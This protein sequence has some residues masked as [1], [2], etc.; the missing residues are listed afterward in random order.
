[1]TELE[2]VKAK[3]LEEGA[4]L[5]IQRGQSVYTS[6][7]RG[8]KPLVDLIQSGE[9]FGGA[10]AAD[11]VVGKGAAFLYVCLKV[12][13]V[14]AGVISKSALKVFEDNGIF[15]AYG[16]LAD[17]IINRKGDGI[18]PFEAAVMDIEDPSIA[19]ETLLRKMAE[20]NIKY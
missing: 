17:N 7:E 18:C 8:V 13:A 16:Q 10:F 20:M 14:Y 5:V 11:R 1:M 12:K 4:T 3:L 9:D 2:T 15:A 19:Y 6:K